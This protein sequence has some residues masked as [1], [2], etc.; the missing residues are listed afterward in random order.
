MA[1][2]SSYSFKVVKKQFG[3][4]S[5]KNALFEDLQPIEA[6]DW[7]VGTLEKTMKMAVISEKS[8]S[9]WLVSPIMIEIKDK[10]AR[11]MNILSG[12]NLDV[13]KELSLTGECD[14]L[15][16]RDPDT[17]TVESP[18]FC[19]VEAERNDLMGGLGQC[20]AQM[21]GARLLNQQDGIELPAIYGCVTTGTDW[22]FLKLENQLI[23]LES[24]LKYIIELNVILGIFQRIINAF[25]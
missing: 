8:R 3:L 4:K 6:S 21:L 14:F 24:N 16:V 11:K 19:L 18:I 5:V 1:A 25:A 17:L 13:D 9:E 20:I 15:F 12:E 7:L 2:Y 23:T 22:Q 10:N